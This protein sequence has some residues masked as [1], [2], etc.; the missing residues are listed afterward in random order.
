M[1]ND[2]FRK[3]TLVRV[4]LLMNC[5]WGG[6]MILVVLAA[7][8]RTDRPILLDVCMCLIPREPSLV[9]W[10]VRLLLLISARWLLGLS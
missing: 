10:Q 4:C 8:E 9:N 3:I 2:L 6:T 1:I 7:I 5:E